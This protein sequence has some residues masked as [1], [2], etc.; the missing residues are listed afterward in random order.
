MLTSLRA[1]VLTGH[2]APGDQ[3]VQET[4]AERYG[5]SR[6]PLR[7]ALKILEGEGL[8]THH[9]HRGYFVAE[10]SIEDLL[11]VYRIREILEA[12]ALRAAVPTMDAAGLEQI[13]L[14][15]DEVDAAMAS[16]DLIAITDANRRF[17]FAMFEASGMP[18]LVRL[19]RQLWDATDVY[20]SVYFAEPANRLQVGHEHRRLLAAL[21]AGD[22]DAVIAAQ[23]GHRANAVLALDLGLRGGQGKGRRTDG[24]SGSGRGQRS[25]PMRR[26]ATAAIREGRPVRDS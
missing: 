3:V 11:E 15:A 17:H 22:A 23:D 20:R 16:G 18:R 19:L 2:L 6:V 24:P 1:D 10:L 13:A 12:E 14:L 21:R 25:R 4:L 8:I 9:P 26:D 5:V 7:E